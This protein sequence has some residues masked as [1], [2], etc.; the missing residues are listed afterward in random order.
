MTV[1]QASGVMALAILLSRVLG[2]VRDA[3]ISRNFG[4]ESERDAYVAA[5]A[6]PDLLFFLIAGGALSAAFIPVFTRYFTTGDEKEAWKVFSTLATFM[7]IVVLCFVILASIFALPIMS[8]LRPGLPPDVMRQ[9]AQL[10]VILLPSQIAF[11]LGGLMFGTMNARKHFLVP[12]LAP[13]IYNIGIILGAA[14]FAYWPGWGVYAVAWGALSG[15]LIGNLLIPI[16]AMR[17]FGSAYTPSLN[18]KHEGVR[19]VFK[20]MLPVIFG[21]SLPGVYAIVVGGFGSF[22]GQGAISALDISNRIM[23][24]P[25]GVFGQ[26]LAIAIF[27]TLA[28]LFAKRDAAKFLVA[29]SKTLRTAVFIGLFV[30]AMIFVLSE[31]VVR[32]LN[33][34]GKFQEVD[35]IRVAAA[36]RMF[37]VGV[38][39]WCAHPILMRAFF[40]MENTLLPILLGTVA[41]GIFVALAFLLPTLPID[42]GIFSSA[43]PEGID[44]RFASLGLSVSIAAIALFMMLLLALRGKL[45][46]IDGSRLTMLILWGGLAASGS[47]ALVGIL[48]NLIPMPAGDGLGPN[49]V[50]LVRVLGLGLAG[51]WLFLWLGRLLGLEEATYAMRAIGRRKSNTEEPPGQSQ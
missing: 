20:L 15:A 50:S 28:E 2:L 49:A 26:S 39:A 48:A 5:F 46:R 31:D 24:A 38:F 51:T 21:L 23:Q 16:F 10:S 8:V 11:F 18:L 19:S 6:I 3:V 9:A 17:R 41:T 22:Y 12:A 33:Q 32:L 45:G 44:F 30:S 35:T 14:V 43:R 42:Y 47:A 37:S 1:V 27:P 36:L 13:N 34:Y 4:L 29:V 25:L 7:G 40:A